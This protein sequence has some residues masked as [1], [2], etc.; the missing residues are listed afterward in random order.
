MNYLSIL[1]INKRKNELL[2]SPDA[3]EKLP[4]FI[5][6]LERQ[7]E[8]GLLINPKRFAPEQKKT[9]RFLEWFSVYNLV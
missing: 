2:T 6:T 9:T 8:Y 4:I 3:R 7:Q 5:G 1:V